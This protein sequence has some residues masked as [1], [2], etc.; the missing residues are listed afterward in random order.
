MLTADRC[1]QRH[2]FAHAGGS[3][4]CFS[5]GSGAEQVNRTLWQ[6]CAV[7]Q[8]TV[9]SQQAP[10]CFL[11]GTLC[12]WYGVL[13]HY[14]L[15]VCPIP[16]C[17]QVMMLVWHYVLNQHRRMCQSSPTKATSFMLQITVGCSQ[18]TSTTLRPSMRVH[19][20]ASGSRHSVMVKG[21]NDPVFLFSNLG[22]SGTAAVNAQEAA[23]K[24]PYHLQRHHQCLRER[25]GLVFEVGKEH[26]RT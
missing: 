26:R 14:Q 2:C 1:S 4:F 22:G 6:K 23:G 20:V 8:S 11:K 5:L 17:I 7:G 21:L 19:M 9:T 24:E 15:H 16:I 12:V 13:V 3:L 10:V 18:T 25:P